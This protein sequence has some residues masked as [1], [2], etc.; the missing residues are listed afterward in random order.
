[1][2]KINSDNFHHTVPLKSLCV[3]DTFLLEGS[4]CMIAQRNGHSFVLVLR[5]GKDYCSINPDTSTQPVIP[6]ECE[7]SYKVQ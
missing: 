4:V 7:L 6:V 1:M 3:G 5:N 2:I